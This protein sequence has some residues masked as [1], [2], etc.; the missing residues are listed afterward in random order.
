MKTPTKRADNA[1][2]A[3]RRVVA[4]QDRLMEANADAD[5]SRA[6]MRAAW[7][8]AIEL[9]RMVRITSRLVDRFERDW[10]R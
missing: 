1:L 10:R 3:M 4:A 5:W 8:A 6:D 2:R 7:A 9:K